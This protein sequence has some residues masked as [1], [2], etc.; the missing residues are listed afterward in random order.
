[1]AFAVNGTINLWSA[2][3]ESGAVNQVVVTSTI[4]AVLCGLVGHPRREN[5]TY[6][7]EDWSTPEACASYGN[8]TLT[9]KGCVRFCERATKEKKNLS[10]Q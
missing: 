10:F 3:A 5:N 6:I 8:K 7:E 2:C 1:M 4:A 9:K